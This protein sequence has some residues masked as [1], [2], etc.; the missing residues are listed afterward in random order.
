MKPFKYLVAAG[1]FDRLHQGHKKFLEAAFTFSESIYCCLT[2]YQAYERL[3]EKKLPF[4]IQSFSKRLKNLK[5]YLKSKNYLE[6]TKIFCLEDCF[7]PSIEDN[8]LEAIMATKETEEGA[9]LVNQKRKIL[10]L[11]PLKIVLTEIVRDSSSQYLSSSNIRVGQVN[12]SGLAYTKLFPRKNLYL[13]STQKIYF[14]K[15]IGILL[16]GCRSHLSW[17]ALKASLEIKKTRTPF[18]ITVGDIST[19]AFL[20][21]KIPFNLAI[22]DQKTRREKYFYLNRNLF[23]Q[24]MV[25]KAFNPPGTISPSLV[26]ALQN[27]FSN[28]EKTSVLKI[29][30][31]EDLSVLPCI[32]LAPL[33]TLIFYGFFLRG[34]VKIKVTE[35]T[36]EKAVKLL[37]KFIY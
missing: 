28:L 19:Q 11:K 13:P 36:K 22:I 3:P 14:K 30:G 27:I 37:K 20:L 12:S 23:S 8:H 1:T 15:P 24:K 34:M 5:E 2:D 25:F 31:E 17:A 35:R 9:E 16:E 26:M 10:G 6:R 29:D 32:L 21:H 4:L 33:N 7:G 18:I